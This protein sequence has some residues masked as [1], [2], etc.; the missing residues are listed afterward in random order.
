MFQWFINFFD[1]KSS[2]GAV[3]RAN[4]YTIKSEIMPNQQLA[5]GLHKAIIRKCEKRKVYSSFKDN[6]WGAD[7]ADM[8]LIS[9]YSKGF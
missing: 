4:K 6:I 3:T 9:K 2:E 1:R 5:Q 7:L 8:K